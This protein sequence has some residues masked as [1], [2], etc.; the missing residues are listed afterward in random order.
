MLLAFLLIMAVP[1]LPILS[2][3]TQTAWLFAHEKIVISEDI[4]GA[5][6]TRKPLKRLDLNF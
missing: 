1:V 6:Q 5:A 4:M 3:S 2:A